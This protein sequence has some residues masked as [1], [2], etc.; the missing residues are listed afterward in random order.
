MKSRI[1]AG[2]E[3]G[4]DVKRAKRIKSVLAWMVVNSRGQPVQK[5]LQ[6]GGWNLITALKVYDVLPG[7]GGERRVRIRISE[8]R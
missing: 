5:R 8:V 6:W 3:R 1:G 4:A 2:K 7:K